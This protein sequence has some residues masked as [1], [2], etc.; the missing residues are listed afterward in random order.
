VA[1]ETSQHIP[2]IS[3]TIRMPLTNPSWHL[4]P[5][6]SHV[7]PAVILSPCGA[8]APPLSVGQS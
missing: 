1:G 7:A 2:D 6:A 5:S 8:R 3:V 4:A